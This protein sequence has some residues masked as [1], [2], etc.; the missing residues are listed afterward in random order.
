MYVVEEFYSGSMNYRNAKLIQLEDTQTPEENER[1]DVILYDG[2]TN[3]VLA[4]EVVEIVGTIV[5]ENKSKT[6]K[7]INVLHA[8]SIK[9]VNKKELMITDKDILTFEKFARYPN[10]IERLVSMVAP[11]VYGHDAAKLGILRSILGG[12]EKNGKRGRINT[13]LVGTLEPL[14]AN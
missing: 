1:L 14:K 12:N 13:L 11:N 4:G 5:I 8:Q 2:M 3:G 9:Y 7:K 10:V 6:K